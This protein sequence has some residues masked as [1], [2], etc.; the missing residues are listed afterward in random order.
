[1]GR[2][3]A[4]VFGGGQPSPKRGDRLRVDQ[5]REGGVG[6]LWQLVV[7]DVTE[8]PPDLVELGTIR[9]Q[10]VQVAGRAVGCSR[11]SKDGSR[12]AERLLTVVASCRQQGQLLLDFLVTA[13]EATLRASPPPSLVVAR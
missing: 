2:F 9:W 12:F 1:M 13:G 3:L 6:P 8:Q 4:A 7:L 11:V 10:A 5:R